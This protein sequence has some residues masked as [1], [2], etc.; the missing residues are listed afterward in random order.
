MG[1]TANGDE[2]ALL[3][4]LILEKRRALPDHERWAKSIAIQERLLGLEEFNQSDVI[5]IFLSFKGEVMTDGIVR[6]TLTRGK[7]VVVPVV[8]S[9]TE[10]LIFS[11]LKKYPDE[12]EPGVLGI[13]EPKKEY[14][15]R[16]E[17]GLIDLFVLPGV[18]F[19][20]EGNRLGYGRGYYDRMLGRTAPVQMVSDVPLIALAF[21][22]QLVDC[23]PSSVHDVRVHKIVTENR[24]IE[25]RKPGR[26]KSW[27]GS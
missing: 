17:I 16:V 10:G 19:D 3:R 23:I 13:P 20:S 8:A 25:C 7:R 12:V 15:R 21:E 24:V 6:K 22:F 11:E 9:E 2:K 14:I 26:E 4:K 18:A 27:Q 1:Q 5:H